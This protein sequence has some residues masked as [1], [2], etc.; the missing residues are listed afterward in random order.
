MNNL[1]GVSPSSSFLA[2][3]WIVSKLDMRLL[4]T[5]LSLLVKL[6]WWEGLV[7]PEEE[8]EDPSFVGR[9]DAS[10]DS[11]PLVSSEGS[12]LGGVVSLGGSM[13]GGASFIASP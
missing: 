7:T 3:E 8:E 2:V 5:L 1:F 12:L 4:T 6:P 10:F 9:G 11:F 13:M